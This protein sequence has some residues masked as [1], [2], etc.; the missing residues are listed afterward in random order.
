MT[1][2][3]RPRKDTVRIKLPAGYK[4]DEMPDPVHL[5][6]PY[7]AY[8]AVWKAEGGDLVFE[9]STEVPDAVAPAAQYAQL[10][11]FFDRIAGSQAS[12]VVLVRK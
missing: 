2:D 11:A 8:Q 1:P 3:D 6:S 7:G 12:P 9:Q 5:E 4:V 10:R